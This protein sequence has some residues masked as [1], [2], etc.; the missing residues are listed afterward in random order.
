MH[1]YSL[2]F[3][4]FTPGILHKRKGR[5]TILMQCHAIDQLLNVRSQDMRDTELKLHWFI[6]NL[7][8]YNC[9]Q[10]IY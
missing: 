9:L 3:L 1:V 10:I 7:E 4:M 2:D 8:S 6:K 5:Q